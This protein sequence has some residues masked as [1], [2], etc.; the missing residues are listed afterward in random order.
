MTN[1]TGQSFTAKLDGT[2]APLRGDPEITT[3][4]VKIH[5]NNTLEEIDKRDGKVIVIYK[6]TVSADGKTVKVVQEDKLYGAT[7]EWDAQKQ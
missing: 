5:G 6:M 3:V 2:D 4:S 1:P 7:I